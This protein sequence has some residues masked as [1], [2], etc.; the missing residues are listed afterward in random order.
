MSGIR[1]S[2][3][4]GKGGTGKTTVSTALALT[5]NRT[6]AE[7][8]FLDCDVEEP[9]AALFLKP[10]INASTPITINSPEVDTSKCTG[11]RDCQDACQYNAIRVES[12]T[13]VVYENMCHGCGGCRI[14]CTPG[15][16]REKEA[17]VGTV[18]SGERESIVFHRGIL[19]VGRGLALPV[20]RGLKSM[21]RGDIPTVLD[22]GPG[23]ASSVIASIKGCDYC[24]LVTEPTPLG[25]YDLQLTV[26][27]VREIGI[28]FGIFINKDE[29]WSSNI[30]KYALDMQMPIL[31]RIP[32]S[33]E[34]ASLCSRGI[35]LTD[36]DTSWDGAFFR[37][38]TD[39]ERT[40]W[41]SQSRSL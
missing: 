29:S 34:I 30:E 21:A 8:Q 2:V 9:D 22:C 11:C 7:T 39:I 28:P 15:A 26:R 24:L 10:R 32:F 35:A 25:F 23:I 40:V 31:M 41:R 6:L 12:G 4:S 1:I 16:I 33:R 17:R 14:V 38:Y 3:A 37:M 18:E 27:M 5:L 19:D 36:R 13:A 20:I